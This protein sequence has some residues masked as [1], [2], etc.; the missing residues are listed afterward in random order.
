MQEK[1]KARLRYQQNKTSQ[2]FRALRMG[3]MDSLESQIW[4]A[5]AEGF[6]Q[7]HG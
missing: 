3:V 2:A 1:L 4:E 5:E 7:I 6:L